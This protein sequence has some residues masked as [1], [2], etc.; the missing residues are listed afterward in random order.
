M[1]E[2]V[3][4]AFAREFGS[5]DATVVRR[6]PGRTN[7][8]GGHV[9]Y[10]GGLV[11]PV[12]INRYVWMAARR[13]SD[14]LIRLFA[15]DLGERHE[16]DIRAID[17]NTTPRWAAYVIGVLRE[18]EAAG[19]ETGGCEVAFCGNVPMGSGLSS[20]AALEVCAAVTFLAL[21]GAHLPPKEV[22][23]LCRRAEN[24]FV[25]VNCGIMDQFASYLCRKDHALLINC[26]TLK[27]RQIPLN[28]KTHAIVLVDTRRERSLASSA[29]NERVAQVTQAFSFLRRQIPRIR[30][31]ADVSVAEITARQ[32]DMDPLFFRRA[33][34]VATEVARV[35]EAVGLLRKGDVDGFGQVLYRSH[36][37]LR[38]LYEVSCEELDFI[39]DFAR[40]FDGAA[41]AR[42]TGGGF[43]GC[44]LAL[45]EKKRI[46]AF[47]EAL[48]P[49]YTQRFGHGAGFIE[50]ESADGA[51]VQS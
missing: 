27:A 50:V 13:R 21:A 18:L 16:A 17:R 34:H 26:A 45:I 2:K 35:R 39:V 10:S 37:S 4:A 42:L 20:S 32:K 14:T 28:L 41:G 15:A 3:L 29:Y 5:A 43:G 40:R 11:L 25:G 44:I 33:L 48:Q 51:S 36:E 47:R 6:A 9:D 12:A 7:L 30:C 38:D 22:I 24:D 1:R 19:V 8:I 31:L 46:P 49:V 23:T